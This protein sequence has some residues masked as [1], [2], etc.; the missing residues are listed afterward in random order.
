MLKALLKVILFLA[1]TLIYL[2]LLPGNS[3]FFNL[4]YIVV[5]S[6]SFR[7]DRKYTDVYYLSYLIFSFWGIVAAASYYISYGETFAPYVDDTFYF[8]NINNVLSGEFDT[9]LTLYEIIVGLIYLPF[10]SF[11]EIVHLDL[12]PFNWFIGSLAVGQAIKLARQ[13]YPLK[14]KIYTLGAFLLIVANSNFLEGSV[15]LYRDG[16]MAFFLL[17]CLNKATEGKYFVALVFAVF[18][19]LIRGANG[20]LALFYIAIMFI[21]SRNLIRSKSQ[22]GV[23]ISIFL[24]VAILGDQM[25]GYS[26]Y[27]RSFNSEGSTDNISMTERIS[28]RYDKFLDEDMG[29]IGGMLQS[30]NPILMAAALPI[31]MI[32]PI[33][34]KPFVRA[35]YSDAWGWIV[36]FRSESF[37]EIGN[38]LL[39]SFCFY[40]IILG[41]WIMIKDKNLKHFG[42]ILFFLTT[43]IAISYISMQLRHKIGYIILFPILYNA[44][45][46]HRE[47]F[48]RR[49]VILIQGCTFA[50]LLLYNIYSL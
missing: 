49:N 39:W 30:G 3:Y 41:I 43:L 48:N 37:W 8:K 50:V 20:A 7:Y 27:M 47:K 13:F 2:Y 34:V 10:S 31:T 9:N 15:H 33:Q 22:A 6:L 36:R 44:Y 46:T 18:T 26:N 25:I 21:F 29:G 38:I 11:K 28:N 42:A 35:E 45:Y 5:L 14:N 23:V 1:T 17:I 4:F 32:S 16:F 40:P 24:L 12:L 19:G